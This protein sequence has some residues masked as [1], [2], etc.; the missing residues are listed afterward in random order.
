ME[1]P[2]LGKLCEAGGNFYERRYAFGSTGNLSVRI[3]DDV[4]MTPTG[5]SLKELTPASLA[6]IDLSGARLN[7]NAPSKEYPFHIAVYQSREDARAIVH[8]H[9][10]YSVALS[11]LATLNPGEP[12]PV[13]TPYYLMRVAPLAVLPYFR[14]GSADLARAVGEAAQTHDCLLLRNHGLITLGASM[15]EAVDRAEELE[16]TARLHFLLRGEALRRLTP[17]EIEELSRA[18]PRKR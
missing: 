7:A 4:W 15:N 16:E 12:L 1:Q 8:L 5:F 18:F 10:T 11:C 17:A 6:Q 13:I 3:G 14:P 9:S 2:E